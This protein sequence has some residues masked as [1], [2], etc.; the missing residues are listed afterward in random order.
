MSVWKERGEGRH[1]LEHVMDGIGT[2]VGS[3]V[4]WWRLDEVKKIWC[5]TRSWLC[6]CDVSMRKENRFCD[7]DG[8]GMKKSGALRT[9]DEC[10]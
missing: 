1:L 2:R 7:R 5:V 8:V 10:V 9:E 4:A 3:R 6:G